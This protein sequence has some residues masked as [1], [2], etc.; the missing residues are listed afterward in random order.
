MKLLIVI[1]TC[2]GALSPAH[3]TDMRKNMKSMQANLKCIVKGGLSCG[4]PLDELASFQ[5]SLAVC[6]KESD[7]Y[8]QKVDKKSLPDL[9]PMN[10]IHESFRK[11]LEQS[12]ILGVGIKNN[13]EK[14]KADSLKE[15]TAIL[16]K[17]HD[18]NRPEVG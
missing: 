4:K 3:A 6:D 17:A 2:I 7:E 11:I 9:Q 10:L 8:F 16:R 5:Q 15:I 12:Q 18:L 14:M 13:D 1:L